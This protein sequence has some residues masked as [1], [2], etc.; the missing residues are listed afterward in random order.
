MTRIRLRLTGFAVALAVMFG[1]GYAV[2]ARF[3][4]DDEPAP[5]MNHTGTDH[6]DTEPDV[7]DG[8]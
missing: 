4:T 7:G 3:P 8:S 2:G 6:V 1:G 5:E